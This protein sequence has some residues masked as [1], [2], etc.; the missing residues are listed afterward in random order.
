MALQ[1]PLDR[2]ARRASKA[3]V[4]K[5]ADGKVNSE[6][7]RGRSPG[8]GPIKDQRSLLF[9]TRALRKGGRIA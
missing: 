9:G 4:F 6:N 5:G 2:P 8:R 7:I 3:R 1:P